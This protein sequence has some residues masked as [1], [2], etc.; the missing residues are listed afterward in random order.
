MSL[1]GDSSS[2]GWPPPNQASNALV[3]VTMGFS[4][5]ISMGMQSKQEHL[6][7]F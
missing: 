1:Q 6:M 4:L 7:I 3:M 2:L 5:C